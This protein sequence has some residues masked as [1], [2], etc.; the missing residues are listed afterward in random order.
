MG[1]GFKN[2]YNLGGGV[3]P[4]TAKMGRLP[5]KGVSFSGLQALDNIDL[6][7]MSDRYFSC[8]VQNTL[9]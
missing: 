6:N 4:L 7:Q 3:L 5:P 9:K 8:T 2:I 1:F